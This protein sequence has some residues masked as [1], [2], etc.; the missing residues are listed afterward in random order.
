MKD[1][2]GIEIE[3]ENCDVNA[4]RDCANWNPK[5]GKKGTEYCVNDYFLPSYKAYEARIKELRDEL[6]ADKYNYESWE[7][8]KEEHQKLEA[9][10]VKLQKELNIVQESERAEAQEADRLRGEIKELEKKLTET[11]KLLGERSRE[12]GEL[13]AYN[14]VLQRRI[15]EFSM[16]LL[17]RTMKENKDVLERLKAAES[18]EK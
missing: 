18:E 17:D 3:C 10:I 6:Y 12:C 5:S 13:E 11:V 2:N 7:E 9:T 15:K 8:I 1:K 4:Q 16:E 14:E